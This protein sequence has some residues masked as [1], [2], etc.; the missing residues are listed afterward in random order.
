LRDRGQARLADREIVREAE[1]EGRTI[2]TF[3]LDFARIIALQRLARP[4]VVLFRLER[5]KTDEV[6]TI[7]AGL[8]TIYES[9]L[10]AGAIL[11][12][13]AHRIRLRSLPIW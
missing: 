12:V 6:N 7:L 10:M 2:V 9:E 3:D 5:F 11:V 1:A 8:L 4:S 13:D